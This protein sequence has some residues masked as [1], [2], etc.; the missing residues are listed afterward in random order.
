MCVRVCVQSLVCCDVLDPAILIFFP[1]VV[2]SLV[3]SI[4]GPL[5]GF[6]A[7]KRLL[8]DDSISD[9]RLVAWRLICS[10]VWL[11]VPRTISPPS[12]APKWGF[13]RRFERN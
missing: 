10:N 1:L 4:L 11:T 8:D 6:F 2:A 3:V 9:W 5:V 13:K 12:S 7:F